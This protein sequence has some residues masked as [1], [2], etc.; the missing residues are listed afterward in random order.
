[1]NDDNELLEAA[2]ATIAAPSVNELAS[3]ESL[4][5][6]ALQLMTEIDGVEEYGKQLKAELHSITTTKLV[7]ALTSAGT[8]EFK[9]KGVKVS[10]KD[11]VSGSLPKDP[12]ARASALAWLESA[13]A[14]DLIKNHLEVDF[15]KKQDNVAGQVEEFLQ[16]LGLEFE[17]ARDVHHS[18]L[19]AFAQERLRAGEETPLEKLGLYAGRKAEIKVIGK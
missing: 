16:E 9:T 17:R 8:D 4:V 11:F 3:I 18:S 7:D 14:Q 2:A 6:R 5:N 15:D 13:G 12:A 19:K 10:I 1:M